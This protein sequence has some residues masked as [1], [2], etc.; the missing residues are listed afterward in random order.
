[1][2]SISDF[3]MN[4]AHA[5]DAPG[6]ADGGVMQYLPRIAVVAVF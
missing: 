3:L 6:M 2:I 5:A 1:M 4:N